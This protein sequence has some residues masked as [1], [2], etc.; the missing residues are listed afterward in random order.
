MKLKMEVYF[1]KKKN[2]YY[3]TDFKD[4]FIA[5]V[6]KK[7]FNQVL[8]NRT[9]IKKHKQVSYLRLLDI[10][11]EKVNELNN[12]KFCYEYLMQYLNYLPNDIQADIKKEFSKIKL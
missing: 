6:T 8:K 10:N 5:S 7:S 11:V 9:Y 4:N 2:K 3:L 1:H 12:Y